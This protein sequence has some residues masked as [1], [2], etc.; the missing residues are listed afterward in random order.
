MQKDLLTEVKRL[1]EDADA[2][3]YIYHLNWLLSEWMMLSAKTKYSGDAGAFRD[4]TYHTTRIVS[5]IAKCKDI[6]SEARA[7]MLGGGVPELESYKIV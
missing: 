7:E 2:S 5:F 6:A 1:L 4:I 3:E